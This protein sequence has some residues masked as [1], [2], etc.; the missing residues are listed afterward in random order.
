MYRHDE[1]EDGISKR[2]SAGVE[3]YFHSFLTLNSRIN[4]EHQILQIRN[5]TGI[6]VSILRFVIIGRDFIGVQP[7]IH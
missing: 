7:P 5:G 1:E 2:R 6:R 4:A 3:V